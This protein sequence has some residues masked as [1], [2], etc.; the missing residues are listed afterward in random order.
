MPKCFQPKKKKFCFQTETLGFS[1][2]TELKS[3]AMHGNPAD[4]LLSNWSASFDKS[5]VTKKAKI[6]EKRTKRKKT[7]INIEQW[8]RY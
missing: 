3:I 4:K 2:Q 1:V 5:H 7:P 6:K 8:H